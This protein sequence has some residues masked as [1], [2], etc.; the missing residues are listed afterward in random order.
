MT[1]STSRLTWL[2]SLRRPGV[3]AL[4]AV[5]L[6]AGASFPYAASA[7]PQERSQPATIAPPPPAIDNAPPQGPSAPAYL[8]LM[9]RY[10]DLMQKFTRLAQDP[11][12]AGIAGVFGSK[13]LLGSDTDPS[14][15]IAFFTSVLPEVKNEAVQRAIRI[16]LI[17][18]YKK[19]GQQDKALEQLRILITSAPPSV[20]H[21]PPAQPPQ[22]SHEHR[23]ETPAPAATSR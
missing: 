10:L 13:D 11:A 6:C 9:D 15:A 4:V 16:E 20:P 12:A 2:T 19:S 1:I 8:D 23:A 3:C 17:D 14:K 7:A 21:E 22:A 5:T 18:L